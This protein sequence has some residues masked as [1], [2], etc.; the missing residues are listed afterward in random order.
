MDLCD[1]VLLAPSVVFVLV[2]FFFAVLA[3]D[4]Y[5]ILEKKALLQRLYLHVAAGDHCHVGAR[6]SFLLHRPVWNKIDYCIRQ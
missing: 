3:I 5:T 6:H 4:V 2:L 1:L